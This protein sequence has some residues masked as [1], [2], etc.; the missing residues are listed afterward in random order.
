MSLRR[1]RKLALGGRRIDGNNT[2]WL[3]LVGVG[4]GV[5]GTKWEKE[6]KNKTKKEKT[7]KM[8]SLRL[9]K[10]LIFAR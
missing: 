9:R 10:S 7:E 6:V 3:L 4:D 8:L 1:R 5:M 2:V